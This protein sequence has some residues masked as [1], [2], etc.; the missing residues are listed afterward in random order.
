M[1]WKGKATTKSFNNHFEDNL[2]K[3][4]TYKSAYEMTEDEHKEAFGGR[5]YS[6]YNTFCGCRRHLLNKKDKM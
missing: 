1:N 6:D 2:N 4:K 5:K 3:A